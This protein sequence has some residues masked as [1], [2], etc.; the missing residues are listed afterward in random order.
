MA[1]SH[2]HIFDAQMG[3]YRRSLFGHALG[4]W[5]LVL[6]SP[7]FATRKQ[8]PQN[9]RKQ[10]DPGLTSYIRP[11][12]T[13]ATYRDDGQSRRASFNGPTEAFGSTGAPTQSSSASAGGISRPNTALGFGAPSQGTTT[14]SSMYSGQ[15]ESTGTKKMRQSDVCGGARGW[16]NRRPLVVSGGCDRQVKV[17]DVLTG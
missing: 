8:A 4:V 10:T 6:V 13:R 15:T 1:N 16:G 3:T 17:W 14:S 12:K 2:I 9:T 11:S 5:T 7:Y